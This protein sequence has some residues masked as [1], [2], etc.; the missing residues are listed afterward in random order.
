MVGV[1]ERA[2]RRGD[3]A[4]AGGVLTRAGG[5]PWRGGDWP[6]ESDRAAARAETPGPWALVMPPGSGDVLSEVPKLGRGEPLLPTGGVP[7]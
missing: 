2:L 7:V 5:V 6:S 1:P 3:C 4:R